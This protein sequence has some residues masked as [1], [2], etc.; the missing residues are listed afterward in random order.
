MHRASFVASL[1]GLDST[2]APA[3]AVIAA[4]HMTGLVVSRFS[5]PPSE[6]DTFVRAQRGWTH[7]HLYGWKTVIERVF[8]HECLYLAAREPG[9]DKIVA[10]L[11]LVR[12]RSVIFGHYLVSMP[13]VNYGGPLGTDDGIRRLTEE[14]VALASKG[15]A[16]LLELRSRVDLPIDLPVSHRKLTVVLDMMPDPVKLFASLPA[17][18][19][20][21]IKRP[22]KEGIEVRFGR[23]QVGAFHEVF[24]Q[25]MRDLGTPVQSR[26]LFEAIADV[27]PDD[28]H[29]AVAYHQ[30]LPVACG[31][32]FRW[33]DEFEIT[34][35]SALRSH[36]AMSP[37]MLVYWELMERLAGAGVTLFNFGRCTKDSGTYKFKMQWGGREEPLWWYQRASEPSAA[38]QAATPSQDKGIFAVATRVW[39][40]LPVPLTNRLGPHIVRFLP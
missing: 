33:A 8:R 6:W 2:D 18:L 22:R 3:A 24:A 9:T 21:Q 26:A 32:G 30:N 4:R 35:A 23:D 28:V 5:G 14:A 10:I 34:W 20:S 1:D 11:P 29:F 13:F 38:G 36:K 27:F 12:V 19:R 15:R 17:K 7:F 25:H 39:Q 37:N 31:C 40:R 16:R